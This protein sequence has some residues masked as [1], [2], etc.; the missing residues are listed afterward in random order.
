[1]TKREAER[2][3]WAIRSAVWMTE[4]IHYAYKRTKKSKIDIESK[5]IKECL[6]IIAKIEG[7]PYNN[8]LK[9]RIKI[10]TK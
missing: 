1:M 6:E 2:L 9:R 3:G 4:I 5:T 10:E 8:S 7:S